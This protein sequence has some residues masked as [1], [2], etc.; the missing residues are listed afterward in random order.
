M[1]MIHQSDLGIKLLN[2]VIALNEERK[3]SLKIKCKLLEPWRES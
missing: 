2:R 1:G 3:L